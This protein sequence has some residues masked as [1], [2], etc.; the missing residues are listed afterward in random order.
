[1]TALTS[2]NQTPAE[3]RRHDLD[4]LRATAMLLG[5]VYHA[6][7]SFAA[8]FPWMVQ[9]VSQIRGLYVFQAATHGFRMPLFFLISGFFTAMLWRKRGLQA[10]LKNRFKRI[11][12]PCL[13]GLVTTV[14]VMFGV[15]GLAL[16]SEPAKAVANAAGPS[17]TGLFDAVV[18]RR[19]P[20]PRNPAGGWPRTN[21]WS[22]TRGS[23]DSS[24]VRGPAP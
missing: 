13:L 1:M 14:P 5:I 11:L 18:A 2:G 10:L 7:L 23:E 21:G 12:L 4:A 9:D 8:G 3:A 22:A 24:T 19:S 15:S 17:G 6:A 16:T 20:S